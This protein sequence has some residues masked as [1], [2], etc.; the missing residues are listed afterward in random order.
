M[1]AT[2]KGA[3]ALLVAAIRYGGVRPAARH[4]GVHWSTLHHHMFGERTPTY[5][6]RMRYAKKF[7]VASRLFDER[8][9]VKSKTLFT[10][11]GAQ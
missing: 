7:G 10:H 9:L 3:E 8:I 2:N 6:F 5:P 4:A 1:I 11:R